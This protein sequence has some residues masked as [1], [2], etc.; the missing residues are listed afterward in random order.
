MG[1]QKGAS[2]RS[3][4]TH[5]DP[6]RSSRA[7]DSGIDTSESR[8]C[9]KSIDG[10][11]AIVTGASAGIG[12]ATAHALAR[13]GANVVLAARRKERLDEIATTVETEYDATAY[14]VQTNVRDEDAVAALVETTVEE[15]YR[16]DKFELFGTM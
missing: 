6:I 13:E 3:Q 14:T 4:L 2:N 7:K 9:H 15:F 1:R 5:T 12:R 10:Q 16:R 8:A 11:T